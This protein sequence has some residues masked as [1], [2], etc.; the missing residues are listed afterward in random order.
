MSIATVVT[1]GYGSFGSVNLVPTFGYTSYVTTVIP[2][3][4][5]CFRTMYGTVADAEIEAAVPDM[6]ESGAV[7]KITISGEPF[8]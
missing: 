1:R 4:F 5:I 7:P 2:E 3:D 8:A 6:T